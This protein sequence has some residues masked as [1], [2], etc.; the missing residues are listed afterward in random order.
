MEKLIEFILNEKGFIF[1]LI[2]AL[3]TAF[4][5]L[6]FAVFK[7]YERPKTPGPYKFFKTLDKKFDLEIMKDKNDITILRD[8]ISR[9]FDR[10]YSL[11]PLLEDYLKYLTAIKTEEVS[12]DKIQQ[13][14]AVIKKIVEEEL[15]EK[16]FA[17]IPEEEKRLFRSLKD[18]I[19]HND[20]QA[21]EF[22]LNELSALISQRNKTYVRTE[23]L[24]RWSLPL[25]IVGLI[26]TI[27]FGYMS[28]SKTIDYKKIEDLNSK[29]ILEQQNKTNYQE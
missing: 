25:A 4:I 2:P 11:A 20:N 28:I 13:R 8:S 18:A 26:T 7:Q 6:I 19:S 15:Q 14:Y 17:D 1:I 22:N 21:L 27:I 12:P 5:P 23:Q 29:L 16:P 24:N 3:L 10:E 9:E